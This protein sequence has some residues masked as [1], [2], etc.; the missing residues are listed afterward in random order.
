MID[1]KFAKL[2][3]R[4]NDLRALLPQAFANDLKEISMALTM[5]SGMGLLGSAVATRASAAQFALHNASA[6]GNAALSQICA[7]KD[8]VGLSRE[9]SSR[10][11][12]R[13]HSWA[14]LNDEVLELGDLMKEV[15]NRGIN[16]DWSGEAKQQ[17]LTFTNRQIDEHNQFEEALVKVAPLMFDAS[18]VT[19]TLFEQFMTATN[20][21]WL[22]GKPIALRPPMPNPAG[23]GIGTRTP[24]LAG[25]LNECA[26]SFAAIQ[27][28]SWRPQTM[29][30]ATRLSAAGAAMKA[31]VARGAL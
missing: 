3:V 10:M 1:D 11:K 28:G 14:Y 22:P 31:S 20:I 26:V 6:Q 4:V 8:W 7:I 25:F 15:Q 27:N 9:S 13:G 12:D 16:N 18:D 24:M 19:D 21:A 29:S 17:W 5:A 23:L 2:D 30:I